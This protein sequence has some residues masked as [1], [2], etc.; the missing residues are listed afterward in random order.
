[1]ILL[2]MNHDYSELQYNN[3]LLL[4]QHFTEHSRQRRGLINGVGYLANT[5]FGVLDQHFADKYSE[6]IE[7]IRN[8]QQHLVNLWRNQTS[9]VESE[10]NLLKRTEASME[11]QYNII[12]SRLNSLD[13]AT[14]DLNKQIQSM[15]EVEDFIMSAMSAMNLFQN[16]KSIQNTLLDT[17]TDVYQ[18]QL[19]AHLL[20]PKQLQSELNVISGQL[21]KDL[22][23]PIDNIQVDLYKIYKLLKIKT[24]I[25][26][27]YLIFEIQ[28]PLVSR[29]IYQMY[30]IIPIPHQFGKLMTEIVAL[31]QYVA[32]NLNKDA[33]IRL[34][35]DEL[36][37]CILHEGHYLCELKS[38]IY[39]L[40]TDEKFCVFNHINDSCK[41]ATTT[42]RNQWIKLN[43]PLQYLYFCCDTYNLRIICD[44]TVHSR[45]I[46]KSG[47]I[48]LQD[49][50][51]IKGKD[52]T[53]LASG[54]QFNTI[55]TA[56]NI[57]TPDV[58][59]IN[60]IIN[61]TMPYFKEDDTDI[62]KLNSSIDGL[63]SQIKSMKSNMDEMPELSSHDIHQ[64]SISY[65]LVG[66]CACAALVVAWR[67]CRRR[68]RLVLSPGAQRSDNSEIKSVVH[69]ESES[70]SARKA[71]SII[72]DS[73]M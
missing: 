24:R 53:L 67:R 40:S 3:Q 34:S 73:V 35:I 6:D 55:Q 14:N 65:S 8:N 42:C 62:D 23:I 58:P 51:Q 66:A 46:K 61:I 50:C 69:N 16:L 10:F 2:Q 27:Q 32:L 56:P 9:I 71:F 54:Q 59:E 72:E 4:T 28:F 63:E 5:L 47:I 36:Q 52:F 17:I 7:L 30:Q 12:S 13:K 21:S 33:Y 31:S 19:N 64:Y 60:H 11:R 49:K 29:D 41:V 22:S 1:M 38:P 18:G 68:R 25:T 26:T 57:L 15:S 43:N 70:V 20:T 48:T 37:G 45:D 39:H 44:N